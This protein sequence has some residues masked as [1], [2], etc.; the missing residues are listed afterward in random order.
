MKRITT[1]ALLVLPFLFPDQL[2][3]HQSGCHRWHSCPSDT[4]SYV[5][6]D[7]GYPCQYDTYSSSESYY[8]PSYSLPAPRN[9]NTGRVE[10]TISS[11]DWCK[12]DVSVFWDKPLYAD[13]FS[14]AASRYAGAD[15]DPI[16]DT[17]DTSYTIHNLASGKWYVNI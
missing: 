8:I 3:A 5:C 13:R 11:D 17:T 9:P 6:G 4:G 10:F 14:I 7:L 15:P 12:Y 16:P 2:L 1:L